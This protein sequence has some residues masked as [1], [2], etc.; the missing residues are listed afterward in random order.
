MS[1]GCSGRR[2]PWSRPASGC[3]SCPR[4]PPPRRREGGR[5]GRCAGWIRASTAGGTS[6]WVFVA[7]GHEPHV[8]VIARSV[9][10]PGPAGGTRVHA[11]FVAP[12]AQWS[13]G[14]AAG[15][16]G[17]PSEGRVRSRGARGLV[18]R[19]VCLFMLTRSL[20]GGPPV[21]GG[22]PEDRMASCGPPKVC[23]PVTA[24]SLSSGS[25][26]KDPF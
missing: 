10:I 5:G 7:R 21:D 18:R 1:L 4:A 19:G 3:R 16:R 6:R 17:R 23:A 12:W 24:A 11:P 25:P 14:A 2:P 13:Q 8:M 15:R 20:S 9:I 26:N 22:A